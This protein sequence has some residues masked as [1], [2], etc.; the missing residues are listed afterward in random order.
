M[1]P[2]PETPT[3]H[4]PARP[5]PSAGGPSRGRGTKSD[6]RQAVLSALPPARHPI[7]RPQPIPDDPT[8]ERPGIRITAPPVYR[9][10]DDGARWSTR[11]GATPTAAYA[12]PCGQTRT[13]RG[14]AA[15][16]ALV[17]DYE[18]HKHACT[19]TPAQH[20]ERRNAA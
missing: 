13:A 16:S 10:H 1:T 17:A 14:A 11:L 20:T 19:G 9:D 8:P 2:R 18:A 4:T 5:R 3:Q 6:G 12:C 15:V 7:C